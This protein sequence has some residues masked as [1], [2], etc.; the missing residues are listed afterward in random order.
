MTEH[1]ISPSILRA[2]LPAL[3][4]SVASLAAAA[5]IP[6][7]GRSLV[8]R[9]ETASRTARGT[10]KTSRDSAIAPATDPALSG[11]SLS[12]TALEC[13]GASCTATGGTG[14]IVLDPARWRGL[15]KPAGS[16]GYRYRDTSETAG[17]IRSVV[18]R[19][20]R[21]VI[22]GVGS[23]WPWSPD[24]PVERVVVELQ[25]GPER[26][27]AEFGGREAVNEQGLL[28][29]VRAPAPAACREY[30][31]NN[32]VDTGESCDG[33]DDAA[34]SGLCGSDCT[35]PA[36]VCGNG[37]VEQSEECDDSAE[38]SC[39]SD[40]LS[41]DSCRCC[42]GGGACDVYPCC[43]PDAVCQQVPGDYACIYP[44]GLG[45]SCGRLY[46]SSQGCQAGLLCCE[47]D[48]G[49]G[50]IGP[51][52]GDFIGECCVDT[53]GGCS[54]DS[55]C[56]ANA[57][58]A[59]CQDG[60]CTAHASA[61]DQCSATGSTVT[62]CGLGLDCCQANGGLVCAGNAG[63]FSGECC[64]TDAT[65][66]SDTECCRHSYG[67]S[68]QAGSCCTDLGAPC[69]LNVVSLQSCCGSAVC[70]KDGTLFGFDAKLCCSLAGAPCSQDAECCTD[71]CDPG[72]NLC[73]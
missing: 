34:C 60:V 58:G 40:V 3:L 45:S 37:V 21:I 68:C 46:D 50:C 32:V 55:E 25:V 12:F 42:T 65:C 59:T 69:Q 41:C 63:D 18:L 52:P 51:G 33:A 17:G 39:G 28:R 26:Y 72:T 49:P 29:F 11:A 62:N 5:E 71:Q 15:G 70:A 1:A 9:G 61:G 38:V 19:P 13:A 35:C 47:I 66:T 73:L 36:P 54:A 2:G 16:R 43:D 27:C 56:C 6:I 22:Q 24:A 23:A 48:G 14:A 20:G 10:F 57:V 30:C 8:V 67:V 53:R 44:S 31:G 7:S 64:V 4:L